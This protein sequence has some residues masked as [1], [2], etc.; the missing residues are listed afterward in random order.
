MD[1][2]HY[3]DT[4]F[5]SPFD[6]FDGFSLTTLP[7]LNWTLLLQLL[8]IA[9]SLLNAIFFFKKVK[10]YHILEFDPK[11][12][13]RSKNI[14]KVSLGE[15]TPNWAEYFPGNLIWLNYV[16][17][18][19]SNTSD[20]E[21]SSHKKAFELSIW[22][23]SVFHQNIFCLFS[24]LQAYI[25]M[26][27]NMELYTLL[28]LF[29]LPTMLFYIFDK[30]NMYVADKQLIASHV[31]REYDVKFVHPR[32]FY[33]RSDVGTSTDAFL[34]TNNPHTF[35]SSQEEVNENSGHLVSPKVNDFFYANPF[36]N[37]STTRKRLFS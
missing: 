25:Y 33:Q 35:F 1:E 12:L 29:F 15:S 21:E 13:P 23:I 11:N 26:F 17:K 14:R 24:P 36:Q 31:L 30:V 18:W 4:P 10:L 19:T 20:S 9:I 27:F 37:A 34:E 8:L 2:Y 28:L 32:V 3:M 7:L 5:F 6:Y 16:K 22:D